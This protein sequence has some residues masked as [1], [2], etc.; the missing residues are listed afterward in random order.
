MKKVLLL[1]KYFGF[2]FHRTRKIGTDKSQSKNIQSG[3][4]K[5]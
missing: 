2:Y 3:N 4:I 1:T 5:P